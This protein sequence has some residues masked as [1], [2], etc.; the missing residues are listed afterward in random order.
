MITSM[1]IIHKIS[2]FQ[3]K[4]HIDMGSV[5]KQNIIHYELEVYNQYAHPNYTRLQLHEKNRPH[6]QCNY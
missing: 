5:W 4:F 6:P 3:T 1:K 2:L